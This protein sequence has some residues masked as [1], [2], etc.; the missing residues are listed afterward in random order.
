MFSIPSFDK[1]NMRGISQKAA[2]FSLV[3]TSLHVQAAEMK[4][5]YGRPLLVIHILRSRVCICHPLCDVCSHRRLICDPFL[6]GYASSF[7]KPC[8][9]RTHVILLIASDLTAAFML[10]ANC[11]A[12]GYGDLHQDSLH[13]L[14]TSGR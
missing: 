6:I 5:H 9:F 10:P 11:G 3:A 4:L 14:S 13:W 2:W 12:C 8:F 1:A 7:S